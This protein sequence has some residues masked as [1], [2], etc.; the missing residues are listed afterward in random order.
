[1]ESYLRNLSVLCISAVSSLNSFTP[2]E[3]RREFSPGLKS[4]AG[5]RVSDLVPEAEPCFQLSLTAS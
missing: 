4:W 3:E 2:S 1:M 5:L